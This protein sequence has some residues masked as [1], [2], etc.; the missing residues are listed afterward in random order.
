MSETADSSQ[1]TAPRDIIITNRGLENGNVEAWINIIQSYNA[2]HP[3]HEVVIFYEGTA[4][5]NMISLFKMEQAPNSN[6]FQMVVKANDGNW[7]NVAKLYRFL[8][9]GASPRFERFIIKDMYQVLKLF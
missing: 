4:V 3:D 5:N 9:E 6:G 7:K 2:V 1:S 8:V